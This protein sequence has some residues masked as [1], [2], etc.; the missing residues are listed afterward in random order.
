[1]E[2]GIVEKFPEVFQADPIGPGY[3]RI[4]TMAQRGRRKCTIG[5]ES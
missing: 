2:S 5:E 1:M 3:G 4:V